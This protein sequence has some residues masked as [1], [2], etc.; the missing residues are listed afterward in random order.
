M[1]YRSRILCCCAGLA[2]AVR[3][4]A[5]D[6]TVFVGTYT[7]GTQSKG[8]YAFHFDSKTGKLSGGTLAA[9]SLNPSF[10]TVH[11]TGRYLYAVNET[12][13][14][15]ISSFVIDHEKL[16][17][18]NS[19]SS[20]GADPCHVA[21]DHTGQWVFVANYTGGSVAAFQ[22]LQHGSLEEASAFDQHSGSSVN[23]QRQEGPHAHVV[24]PSPDNHFLLVADLGTD[25]VLVYHFDPSNGRL[26]P[27][28]SAQ[29]TPG[30][31]PR[32]LVFSKNR[33]FVYV[34]DE[35][36]ATIDLFHWNFRN[37]SLAPIG[38]VPMDPA[39]SAGEKSGAEIVI[40]P[41]GRFLYASNRGDDSISI[42]RVHGGQLVPAGHVASGG[43]TPRSFVMDR[44]GKF[45]LAAN[46]NS[47]SIV[48]FK[49]DP[50]TGNL[51]PTGEQI[52]I[53]S[54]VSVVFAG[55]GG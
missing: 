9:E 35:L 10:L 19:V 11:P 41:K 7:A 42:F 15:A 12:R 1:V 31:G 52:A 25:R 24:V 43:K 2:L 5:A 17:P 36:A 46:Q 47:G 30:S 54:P 53:P 38:S 21:V 50:T 29:L 4:Q 23:G 39:G 18:Q 13:E 8:I 44:S 14:G 20:R 28:E 55:L 32:H 26:A 22:I 16:I 37:G 27:E 6:R 34:L 48:E 3:A 33:K 49:I 45:L 40:D 51:T